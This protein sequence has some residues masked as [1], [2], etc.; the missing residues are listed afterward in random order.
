V[1]SRRQRKRR[2]A[3][4]RSSVHGQCSAG[5]AAPSFTFRQH[6]EGNRRQRNQHQR[7]EHVDIGQERGLLR[8]L[9]ADPGEGPRLGLR[10]VA[11]RREIVGRLLKGLLVGG[12]GGGGLLGKPTEVELLAV[13]EDV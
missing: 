8:R 2:R 3:C 5:A 10:R 6:G 1:T 7:P 9:L 12:V 13:G 11:M 4:A